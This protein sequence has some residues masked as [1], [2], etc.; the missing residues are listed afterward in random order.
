MTEL[1]PSEAVREHLSQASPLDSG[2]LLAIFG[3]PWLLDLCLHIHMAFSLCVCLCPDFPL[4]Q[5]CQSYW[6]KRPP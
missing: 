4:L 6:I 1:T 2:G 5:G 3:V